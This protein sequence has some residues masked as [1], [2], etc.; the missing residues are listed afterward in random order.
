GGYTA[1]AGLV[2]DLVLLRRSLEKHGGA[3]TARGALLTLER[4]VR[5][6]GF[7]LARLDFRQ[8]SARVRAAAEAL[9]GGR[10]ATAEWAGLIAAGAPRAVPRIAGDGLAL[11]EME[12]LA[13]LQKT[14]GTRAA[15]HYIL[16]MTRS[17]DDLWAALFLA[18]RAGLIRREGN[19]WRSTVDIVPLFETVE[20]LSR[21]P[22]LMAAL[23]RHP[24]YRQ[25]LASRGG[26]QEIMLGYSDSNKDAGYLAANFHLFRAQ[27]SLG[28]AAEKA[29]VL[30][31]FFHGKGGTIDRGGGPAHRAILAAPRS[32]PGGRLRITEQGEVIAYKYGR[33]AV[34][35]R[36]FEQMASAVLTAELAPPGAKLSPARRSV[37][38]G[39]LAGLEN[40]LL[41]RLDED[42][43][44]DAFF[45]GDRVDHRGER[46]VAAR[47]PLRSVHHRS[48]SESPRTSRDWSSCS[49][50]VAFA[51]FC[52]FCLPGF[53]FG[54]GSYTRLARC[55][56]A[57]GSSTS[58]T[59][60]SRRSALPSRS[61]RISPL[62][63]LR[64]G[65]A[66]S[67]CSMRTLARRPAKRR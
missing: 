64:P 4:Q 6:F 15:D 67:A 30:L 51:P 10:P 25:I 12:T 5:L 18:R 55:T 27:E 45:L 24:F 7:H 31:R 65:C 20:D 32:V 3:R 66:S 56:C 17:A 39:V 50:R 35:R 28:R 54:A 48:C 46:D 8:H 26:A 58:P 29:G 23:W 63:A 9:A 52:F 11:R 14:F 22:A 37:Y 2:D 49:F 34:A 43:A 60:S 61:P 33:P 44:V 47:G 57:S 1:A 53:T 62:K 41:D 38:E 36:N 19:R 21:A 42:L 16:S 40:G 13:E 59:S